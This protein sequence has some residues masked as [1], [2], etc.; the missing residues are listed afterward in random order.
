ML[1]CRKSMPLCTI[2]N[3]RRENDS[4]VV[5]VLACVCAYSSGD[6]MGV[7]CFENM[8]TKLYKNVCAS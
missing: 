6:F 3:L 7:L 4:A 2:A 5:I 1:D 8:W